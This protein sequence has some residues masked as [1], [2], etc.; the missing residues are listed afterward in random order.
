VIDPLVIDPLVA[1]A[2]Y[3]PD[4][5]ALVDA[6]ARWT[7]REL[8]LEASGLAERLGLVGG[9]RVALLARDTADAVVAIHA[10]RLAGATLVPLNRRLRRAE[11]LPLLLRSGVSLLAHDDAHADLANDLANAIPA[12][13]PVRLG[14]RSLPLRTSSGRELATGITGAI[15]FTSGT[16]GVPRAAMLTHGGLLASAGAWNRFL[17][18]Q[19][20]D[21]WLATLPLSH[22]AG[23]GV[24]LRSACS[25]A[26]LTLHDR[27]D[28]TAIRAALAHDGITHL[29]LVPTQLGRLLDG[30]PVTAPRLRALLLGGAPIPVEL[31]RRAVAAGLPVSP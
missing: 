31:V 11:L 5:E 8:L 24:V 20:N 26:L 16:T 22:V 7:W 6:S 4:E 2:E 9:G 3:R 14:S 27:F 29:S 12:L 30:E 17:E 10:V 13:E 18:A 19:P 1:T 15:V 25:G 21:H 23:L 28:P